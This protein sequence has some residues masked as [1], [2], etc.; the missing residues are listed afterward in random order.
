MSMT[1][2]FQLLKA[3]MLEGTLNALS[4][5]VVFTD[6]DGYVFY[7]NA[8]AARQIS[9]GGAMRLFNNRISPT[10]R[11]AAKA[12]ASALADASRRDGS[13]FRPGDTIG[14]PDRDGA[15][16][17]ATI[18]P[19]GD[20]TERSQAGRYAASAAILLQDTSV[21][22]LCP[23]KAIVQLYGLTGAEMRV[24]VALMPGK[25]MRA[26][27]KALG[28]SLHTVKTHL[29]HIFQKTRTTRQA[30]LV[31]LLWRMSAP[32]GIT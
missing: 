21:M 5:G 17:L 32:V 11:A 25:P 16:V 23:D 27:A 30:E 10:N 6:R 1:L 3:E 22:P 12:L 9:A 31:A 28:V 24:A 29:Q 8:A 7:M 13:K 26:V 18:L 4:A 15:G 19:L 20:R 2:D 14:L